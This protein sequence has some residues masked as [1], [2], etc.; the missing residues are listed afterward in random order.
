VPVTTPTHLSHKIRLD[1]NNVQAGYFLRSAGVARFTYNWGLARWKELYEAGEKP[2]WMSIRKELTSISKEEFP[3]MREVSACASSYS[4]QNLGKGFQAFFRRVK[5]GQTPGYPRFK[6]KKRAKPSFIIDGRELKLENKRIKVPKL[7]WV[8]M[9]EH[10]RFPGKVCQGVFTKEAGHWYVTIQVQLSDSYVYPHSCETQAAVGIDLGV[11]DLAVLS[12]G[13]KYQAP[14]VIR[15][16]EKKLRRINKELAR[17]KLGGKNREKT[18]LKLQRL[19][20]RIANVRSNATHRLTASVVEKFRVIGIEDLNLAGMVRNRR[21]AK[22]VSDAAMGEVAFQLEYK[23]ALAGCTLT[24]ADRWFPSSKTC[25]SCGNVLDSLELSTREWEC[26]A[27][28]TQHDRDINAAINLR[29][30]AQAVLAQ[31]QGSSGTP[32][33]AGVRNCPLAGN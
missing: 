17:R 1:P 32:A 30:A 3:W 31:R 7:G 25:S 20:Q 27:C 22:S 8:R 15:R 19:H 23:A 12:N 11:K 16:Y 6:S 18:R 33:K 14:R 28:S 10:L 26:P 13:E 9:R 5:Q 2:S 29:T 21:L 4:L 24:R